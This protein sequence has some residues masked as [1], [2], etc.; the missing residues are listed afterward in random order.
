[1]VLQQL[2][3]LLQ[4]YVKKAVVEGLETKGKFLKYNKS[5]LILPTKKLKNKNWPTNLA[6]KI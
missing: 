5:D 2:I 6:A 4:L 3:N 1:M